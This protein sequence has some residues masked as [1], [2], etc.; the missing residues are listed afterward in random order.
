MPWLAAGL[1]AP[2]V[3]A[4]ASRRTGVQSCSVRFVLARVYNEDIPIGVTRGAYIRNISELVN[5]NIGHVLF[6]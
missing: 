6:P 1:Q 2:D 3:R 5:V 4:F